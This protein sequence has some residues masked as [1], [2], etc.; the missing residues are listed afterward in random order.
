MVED[1]VLT[2]LSDLTAYLKTGN[3]A[4]YG[5]EPIVGNWEFNAGVTLAWLRQEQPKM[6]ANEMRAV[7][8]LWS[9]AYAQTKLLL[10]C[11]NQFTSRTCPSSSRRRSRT[12]RRF[13]PKTGK[14]IGLV[15]EPITHCISHSMAR[16]SS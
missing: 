9:Q 14:A 6:G 5:G 2:N 15:M 16:T 7:R 12:S 3:S 10:T 11:D 4:K 8:A 1:I 13:N